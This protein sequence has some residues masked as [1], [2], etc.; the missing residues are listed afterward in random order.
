MP[1]EIPDGDTMIIPGGSW[2]AV[3]DELAGALQDTMLRNPKLTA[4]EWGRAHA[5]LQRY[6]RSAGGKDSAPAEV[7]AVP[8]G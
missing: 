3:A 8:E 2:R 5:A 6:E 4:L 1:V 7:P